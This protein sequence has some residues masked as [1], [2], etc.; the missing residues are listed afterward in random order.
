MVETEG[1]EVRFHKPVAYQVADGQRAA[2]GGDFHLRANG[3]VGFRL[4][5]YDRGKSLVIDPVLVYS[6]YLHGGLN[7]LVDDL[8]TAI[9]VDAAGNAYVTGQAADTDFPV[10]PGAFQTTN[11]AAA[12]TLGTNTFITKLNPTGSALV[13]ST[14]LG[15]SRFDNANGLAVDSSGN[16]YVTG[17]T[18]SVDFPVTPGAF[19]TKNNAPTAGS[20]NAFVTKLNPTGSALVYSTFLGGTYLDTGNG[21]AVDGSGNAYV[22]GQTASADFPVTQ[23]AFQ[24]T[25][26]GATNS[27]CTL[28]PASN[29]FVTKLNPTGSALVYS[30]FVGGSGAIGGVGICSG[31]GATGLAVDGSGNAYITGI[32]RSADFPVTSGAFQTTNDGVP[33]SG[34]NAFVTKLNPTGSALVYSTYLGGAYED[35]ATWLAVDGSGNAYITGYAYSTDFPVTVGAFQTTDHASQGTANAFVTKLNPTGSTLDYSTYL[36]GSGNARGAGDE[37]N[38]LAV[39]GSG[40]AYI[41]GYANSTDFPVTPGAFQTTNN[42]AAMSG[43]NAFLTK[44]NATGSALEYSTYLGGSGTKDNGDVGAGL[45]VDGSGNAYITGSTQSLDFP[46]TSGAFQ[47]TALDLGINV[48]VAKVSTTSTGSSVVSPRSVWRSARKT[49]APPARPRLRTVTNTGTTNLTISTVTIGGT[50]ASDF[51]T[52]A[53]TCTGATV[54]PNGTCAVSVTFTPSATGSRSAALDFTDNA[55][56]SPQTVNLTGTGTGGSVNLSTTSVNFGNQTVGTTSAASAVMVTNNGTASLTFTSIAVTGDFAIAASGTTCSTTAPVA[57]GGSCVINVTFTP[58][59]TGSRSGSLT[60]SDNATGSPQIVSLS[61]TG[62]VSVNTITW[63]LKNVTFANGETVSGWFEVVPS[64]PAIYAWNLTFGGL[65]SYDPTSQVGT[66]AQ[67]ITCQG[68]YPP[69]GLGPGCTGGVGF[70]DPYYGGITVSAYPQGNGTGNPFVAIALNGPSIPLYSVGNYADPLIA[71]VSE[72]SIFYGEIGGPLTTS[73]LTT[74]EFDQVVTAEPIVSLSSP[75]L[76]FPAQSVAT[77]SSAQTVTLKNTGSANL[78]F[79]AI[80]ASSPFAIASSGTTCSA[81]TPVAAAATCTVAVTFTP[82]AAGTATGSLSFTDNA[83][84]SPQSVS[85]TGTGTVPAVSLSAPPTFPSEPVGTASPSQTVTVSNTGNG[86]LNFTAIGV[87][88][89]FALAATGTTC[90]TSGPVAVSGSCTVAVTFTPTAAGTA[91]GSLSFNDNAPNS[92]QTVALS[93]TGQ[94]FS[95]AHP[96]VL[97]PRPA[98]APGSPATYTLSVGGEGGLSGT[99]SFTCTG[100][101]SEA[102]CTVSPNPATAGSSASNVTVNVTTTAPSVSAPRSR[103]LPPVAAAI[104]GPERV[105]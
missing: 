9:A 3:T 38:G 37:A 92:P 8:G 97:P 43:S 63:T 16:A 48:F 68:E 23:G 69:A 84:G 76:T 54:T 1:G 21:L 83:S 58:T 44:L 77:V 18:E 87:T 17:Y 42:A 88:G 80:A 82:T 60:L 40:N 91:S 79:T 19:Q 99:V 28:L 105:C 4:G 70:D 7:Y 57:A 31:D 39:D 24:T 52:T 45:A 65:P 25:N 56:S 26:S 93:G 13:Y 47:T 30:T 6:T 5:S 98:V 32:A 95:L 27:A 85:L 50:N 46:V 86:S 103:P 66:E 51:A 90:S 101:P 89:P 96:P 67:L 53:D 75:S 29:A 81:S 104:A 10:T 72:S 2:V 14:Y 74:G 102:T 41:T 62:T 64:G 20:Y 61:G 55:S 71:N 73:A 34:Y 22:T 33:N 35:S 11:N 94:D 49:L 100:A 12:E 59:T 36:G 15:G 78:T